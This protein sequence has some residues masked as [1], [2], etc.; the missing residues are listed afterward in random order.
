[1]VV[2]VYHLESDTLAYCEFGCE[3][4]CVCRR[5]V[6]FYLKLGAIS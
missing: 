2:M 3:N 4:R 6:L 1:M 5:I